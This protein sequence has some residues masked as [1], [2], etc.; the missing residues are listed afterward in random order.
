MSEDCGSQALRSVEELTHEHNAALG[1]IPLA[2]RPPPER[3]DIAG[4]ADVDALLSAFYLQTLTDPVLRPVFVDEMRLDLDE[5]LPVIAAFWDRVLFQAGTYSGRTMDV[6]RRV[7]RRIPLTAAHFDRWLVLWRATVDGL[8][9]GPVAEQA[10]AHAARMAAVFVRNLAVPPA[11]RLL[12]LVL[13]DPPHA[14]ARD[15]EE[16]TMPTSS[17]TALSHEQL[18][19]AKTSTSGR[20]ASTVYGGREHTLRQTMIALV[21]GHRLAEHENPGE[22]TVHVLAGRVRLGCGG[23]RWDGSPGDLI[24]VPDARH[25]LEALE[26]SVVLLTVAKLR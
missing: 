8:F 20:S 15:P 19:L 13:P 16:G 23:D 3:T 17:L 1:S 10:K 12:P 9:A 25:D 22:A 7:H 2:G 11:A 26:D 5:H 14:S 18:Q 24:A 6:H 4:R 21:C